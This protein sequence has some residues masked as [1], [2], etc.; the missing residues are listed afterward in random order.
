M[1]ESKQFKLRKNAK[2]T[3]LSLSSK[4]KVLETTGV[5]K[6]STMMNQ[7]SVLVIQLP[8]KKT[9]SKENIRLIPEHMVLSID[10]HKNGEKEDDKKRGKDKQTTHYA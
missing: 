3:I 5:L 7:F 6:G 4:D 2:I 8:G 1:G 10:V 9:K